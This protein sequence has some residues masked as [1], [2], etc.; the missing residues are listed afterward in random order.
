LLNESTLAVIRATV[1]V[2]KTHGETITRH[3]YRKLFAEHPEVREFFNQAHQ[4]DGAQPRALA[5]AVLAYAANIDRLDAL[6]DALPLIIHKHAALG[7]L[8]EHYPVVGKC[9]L[10]AIAEVLGDA[11]TPEVLDAWAAA[12]GQ[13]AELLIAAEESVYRANAAQPGGWRGPRE[14]RVARKVIESDVITSFHLV[15]V[16][17]GELARFTPGQYVTLLLEI[18]GQKVRRTYS[19]SDAP[20][21]PH[22][23]IS[24]KREPNGVASNHLHDRVKEGDVLKLLPPCGSFTLVDAPRPLVLLT[25][26]VGITPAL[27]MLNA[28]A[29]T[30][31]EIVFIHAARNA[32]VHAFADHVRELARRFRNV[33]TCFVYEEAE[34][35]HL[36][37][38]VGRVTPDVLGSHLPAD[39]D[40][41]LYFLGPKGFMAGAL[42]AARALGVPAAQVRYE[43]FG[44]LEALES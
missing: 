4:A 23:R 12:Y 38:V 19:L 20:G 36:P 39:R 16:D 15:P 6:K 26:G 37:D 29:A 18:G 24:V 31:R 10:A 28:A 41:D 40:V 8:P 32:R 44:P 25:A 3:F 13:L 7:V 11:A 1:P 9:L 27:S 42:K 14:F 17:G 43:F 5:G 2:L 21:Q 35:G 34:S 33:R 30:G 22:Y